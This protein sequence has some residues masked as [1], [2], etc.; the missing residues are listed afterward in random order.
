MGRPELVVELMSGDKE[1]LSVASPIRIFRAASL[2]DEIWC[3]SGSDDD[4]AKK[5]ELLGGIIILPVLRPVCLSV[6]WYGDGE[7]GKL[8]R[9]PVRS[10]GLP[11]L[12]V[13]L[14]IVMVI[15]DG[16]R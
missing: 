1:K 13:S 5:D 14:S 7:T 10:P 4:R 11:S 2:D 3:C 9:V 8:E 6:T 12:H 16:D 15:F